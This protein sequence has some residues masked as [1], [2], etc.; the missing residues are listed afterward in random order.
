MP[1]RLITGIISAM[2][3]FLF[4]A[5]CTWI[6]IK[7]L[8][9]EY[10]HFEQFDVYLLERGLTNLGALWIAVVLAMICGFL[11]YKSLNGFWRGY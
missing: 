6:N 5:E 8:I 3:L 2:L 9:W 11:A 7:G 10:K 1:I 4:G